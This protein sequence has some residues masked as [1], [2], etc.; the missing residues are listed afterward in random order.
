MADLS[1]IMEIYANA[2]AYMKEN[3]NPDQW[4]DSRPSKERV[5]EDIA[6]GDLYVIMEDEEICGVF[7]FI[8]GE[9]PTYNLIE[10]GS[11]PNDA[12]YGTIHRI[13]S[14]GKTRGV[15]KQ[16]IEF[17]INKCDNLRI[18]THKDNK[19]MIELIGK[20]GFKRCGIIYVDD[21]SSR[22]AYQKTK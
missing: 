6:S 18:D 2:R 5:V 12:R 14:S 10:E 9:D 11:W 15:F 1:K 8:I 4:G 20:A 13:A 21:G 22:I 19:V 3:G 16:C 17:C 7:A